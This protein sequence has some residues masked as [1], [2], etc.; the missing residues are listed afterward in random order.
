MKKVLKT[1][2][3]VMMAVMLVFSVTACKDGGNGDDGVG[4]K[5]KK[6]DGVY[7]IYEYVQEEGVTELDLGKALGEGV[8]D[9]RIKK[10]AFSGN[11]KLTKIIVPDVVTKIDAGAFEKMGA[12]VTLELP[13]IGQSAKSDVYYAESKKDEGKAVDSA[14]TIAHIFGAE[15]Y[16]LG[17][18]VTV[19]YDDKST[20]T[21]YMPL[22]FREVIVNATNEYSIPMY[23]FSGA[24]N[25]TSVVLN[26]KVDAIGQSA[27]SGCKELTAIELPETTV[28]VYENAFNGCAKLKTLTVKATAITVKDGAFVGTKLARTAL[29]GKVN[30]LTDAMKDKIFGEVE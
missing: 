23:A 15:E 28:T 26:G 11:S 3:A 13:F 18:P 17:A 20:T 19:S 5:Y 7:T 29:D 9:V 25:L 24:V 22:T 6:I 12:L 16:D 8:T 1:L 2:I 27:F 30:D 14:R 4:V 10:G 21:C